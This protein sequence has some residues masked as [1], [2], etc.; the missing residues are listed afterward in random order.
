MRYFCDGSTYKNGQPGQD[1]SILVLK[2]DGEI[3]REHIGDHSIN[4]AELFA[5]K[6][7]CEWATRGDEIYT[8][9]NLSFNWIN[10]PFKL[11][12][13]NGHLEQ[14]IREIKSYVLDKHLVVQ[15]IPRESNL[16]GLEIEKQPF[17]ES[18][19]P[20][21]DSKPSRSDLKHYIK[22]RMINDQLDEEY[23]RAMDLD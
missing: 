13:R 1:S 15:F 12:K 6:R 7:A 9:S 22:G 3:H 10:K 14:L 4:Y 23:R 20:Q 17:Y 19:W 18:E 2:P 5:I 21:K 16:A 8:D 11:T